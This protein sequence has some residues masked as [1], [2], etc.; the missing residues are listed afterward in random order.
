MKA[1][2]NNVRRPDG[3]VIAVLAVSKVLNLKANH[4]EAFI[5]KMRRLVSKVLNLKA[6]HNEINRLVIKSYAVLAVSKVLNLDS[7][8]KSL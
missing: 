7:R 5:N 1:N 6:N 2:H 8:G 4:N 3:A